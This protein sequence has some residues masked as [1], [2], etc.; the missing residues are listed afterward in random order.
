MFLYACHTAVLLLTV[1]LVFSSSSLAS[2]SRSTSLCVS[3]SLAFQHFHLLL[4]DPHFVCQTVAFVKF[5]SAAFSVIIEAAFPSK[6]SPSP[7]PSH[8]TFLPRV[9]LWFLLPCFEAGGNPVSLSF[10]FSFP[11]LARYSC[12]SNLLLLLLFGVGKNLGYIYF[13]QPRTIK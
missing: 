5:S 9:V 3:P 8:A 7:L 10:S 12:H 2:A 11:R 13:S 6:P 4:P 1:G